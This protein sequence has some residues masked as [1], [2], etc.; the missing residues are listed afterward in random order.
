MNSSMILHFKETKTLHRRE[1]VG[2]NI[3][4]KSQH[5]FNFHQQLCYIWKLK[6]LLNRFVLVVCTDFSQQWAHEQT[7]TQSLQT[8]ATRAQTFLS[9]YGWVRK[10]AGFD[11]EIMRSRT[12]SCNHNPL[13]FRV[14]LVV[15]RR[16]FQVWIYMQIDAETR[17][18]I[19]IY[20]SLSHRHC[21]NL[22]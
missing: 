22:G 20:V 1:I 4:S 2:N 14:V 8:C 19:Y 18:Y 5:F 6:S 12:V 10:S 16:G 9:G 13:E 7:M 15:L 11:L 3:F 17:I 21:E